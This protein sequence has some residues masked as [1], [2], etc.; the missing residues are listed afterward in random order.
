MKTHHAYIIKRLPAFLL[1]LAL[2]FILTC[3]LLLLLG[4]DPEENRSVL[5]FFLFWPCV[6]YLCYCLSLRL[7]SKK[8]ELAVYPDHISIQK[9]GGRLT[10]PGIV[11]NILVQDISHQTS[12]YGSAGCISLT[13]HMANG[14]KM[15]LSRRLIKHWTASGFDELVETLE[16]LLATDVTGKLSEENNPG[17]PIKDEPIITC[18]TMIYFI[19]GPYL[20]MA[21]IVLNIAIILMLFSQITFTGRPIFEAVLILF[22]GIGEMVFVTWVVCL[23]AASD[24]S[25]TIYK[26]KVVVKQL[27]NYIIQRYRLNEVYY[28]D[29]VRYVVMWTHGNSEVKTV[30]FTDKNGVH[31]IVEESSKAAR[32]SPKPEYQI[33]KNL[34]AILKQFIADTDIPIAMKY[35]ELEP[36]ND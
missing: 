30:K 12:V 22:L 3:L 9:V 33:E 36:D 16:N 7:A 15:K 17:S 35:F 24:L 27:K 1:F 6:T 29:I 13:L 25:V 23:L 19:M 11:Q 4:N 10:A 21:V 8:I 5:L 18:K 28:K 32:T 31:Y 26:N 34:T 20:G 14:S 2:F